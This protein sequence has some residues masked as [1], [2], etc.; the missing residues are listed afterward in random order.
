MTHPLWDQRYIGLWECQEGKHIIPASKEF[1]VQWENQ[2]V[3]V[4][5]CRLA[6][7]RVRPL[8]MFKTH[9]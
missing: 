6:L 2:H 5:S 4:S 1:T 3:L 8:M 7:R 9:G